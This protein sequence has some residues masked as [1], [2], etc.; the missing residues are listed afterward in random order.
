MLSDIKTEKESFNEKYSSL[1][2]TSIAGAYAK[3]MVSL[4]LSHGEKSRHLV[5]RVFGKCC[6]IDE[7]PQKIYQ[8]FGQI[9]TK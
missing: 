1:A 8:E 4:N 7:H 2:N 6:T 3:A 9:F 5:V